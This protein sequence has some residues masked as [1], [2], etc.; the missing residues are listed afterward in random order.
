LKGHLL[1]D[2][3]AVRQQAGQH[4][5]EGE[6][7]L[8]EREAEQPEV[9]DAEAEGDSGGKTPGP[10]F[11]VGPFAVGFHERHTSVEKCAQG[12]RC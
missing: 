9:D 11:V 4:P 7:D 3:G 2:D 10:R 12:L 1:P 6:R 5:G 8:R